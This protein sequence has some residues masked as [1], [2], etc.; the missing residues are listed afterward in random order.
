MV[1][2]HRIS[3]AGKYFRSSEEKGTV[4]CLSVDSSDQVNEV[5][6]PKTMKMLFCNICLLYDCGHH[7]LDDVY[8]DVNST[9]FRNSSSMW[10]S[11]TFWRKISG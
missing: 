6:M 7:A 8:K 1:F 3:M 2:F 11:R 10:T 4:L 5:T 9:R